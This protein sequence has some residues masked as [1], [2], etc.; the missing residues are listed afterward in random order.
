MVAER[1]PTRGLERADWMRREAAEW[2]DAG[3]ADIAAHCRGVAESIEERDF[4]GRPLLALMR[5]GKG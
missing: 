4:A 2:T 3:R 5:D 1:C